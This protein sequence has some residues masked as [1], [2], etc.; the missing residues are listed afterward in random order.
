MS[1]G[2]YGS[3]SMNCGHEEL[4]WSALARLQRRVLRI[5]AAGQSGLKMTSAEGFLGSESPIVVHEGVCLKL[6]N[7]DPY[8][9][10]CLY[11]VPFK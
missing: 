3:G 11:Q 9:H 1:I 10:L 2:L 5:L 6:L 8:L 7:L 4:A